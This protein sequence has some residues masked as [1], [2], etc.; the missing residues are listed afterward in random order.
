MIYTSYFAN[1]KKLPQNIIPIAISASIP[2]SVRMTM[3]QKLAPSY[4]ILMTWKRTPDREKYIKDYNEQVL[5]RLDANKV[6]NELYRLS[7]GKDIALICY[8]K[9]DDFCHRHLVAEWLTESGLCGEV[10]EYTK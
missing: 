10:K 7:H 4:D 2:K 8:E 1:V 9:P 3:Y 6:V 5:S